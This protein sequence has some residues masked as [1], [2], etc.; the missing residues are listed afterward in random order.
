MT[1]AA[2]RRSSGGSRRKS[3]GRQ[4]GVTRRRL[5]G[6]MSVL[7]LVVSMTVSVRRTAEGRRLSETIS[8]MDREE[9][10]LRAQLADEIVRVE[11]LES[12][13][14]VL[15]AASDL[16]LRPA[17]DTQVTYLEDRR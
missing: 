13:P 15:R 12:R 5:L 10:M 2:A 17:E 4:A 16:G 6:M 14:R 1:A 11:S 8:D 3:R 7:F 9:G